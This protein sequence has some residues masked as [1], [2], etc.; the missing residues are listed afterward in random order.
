MIGRALDA[1]LGVFSPKTQLAR[2][3]A[4][5]LI[6]SKR[7]Y[8]AARPG[9]GGWSPIDSDANDEIRA[10][11]SQVRRRVRQL[12]RDH[13]HVARAVDVLVSLTVGNGFV[14]QSQ[15]VDQGR[16]VRTAIEDVFKRWSDQA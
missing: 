14:L 8:A 11:S 2:M 10:S 15:A 5:E 3:T 13:P 7:L 12:V 4:R 16:N 9:M 1:F 6:E